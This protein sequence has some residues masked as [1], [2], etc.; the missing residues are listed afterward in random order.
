MTAPLLKVMP[1]VNQ[2]WQAA[3]GVE[4]NGK[5]FSVIDRFLR[6]GR[7]RE[8]DNAICSWQ[9]RLWTVCQCT[10]DI[11]LVQDLGK[12]AYS[13][14]GAGIRHSTGSISSQLARN[15][16][17]RKHEIKFDLGR[18]RCST[19][20]I[21]EPAS[22]M[23]FLGG[24]HEAPQEFDAMPR[25]PLVSWNTMLT[26][27][28]RSGYLS[29]A[30]VLFDLMPNR[31][32]VSWNAMISATLSHGNFQEA[33]DL[34]DTMPY[35]NAVSCNIMIVAYTNEGRLDL[36]EKLFDAMP[37][38][39]LLCCNSMLRGFLH[40][41]M[42]DRAISLFETMPLRDLVTWTTMIH[43]C[44]QEEEIHALLHGL[45]EHDITSANAA[46][47]AFA[48][49]GHM[50]SAKALLESME[51]RDLVSLNTMLTNEH[52]V[53]A[54][55]LAFDRMPERDVITFNAMIKLHAQCG[56]T[57]SS[58]SLFD[59]CPSTNLSSWNLLLQA[60][61]QNG[62]IDAG[63]GVFES[64]PERSP[65]SHTLMVQA[66]ALERHIPGVEYAWTSSPSSD[67]VLTT[68]VCLA[69]A[70]AGHLERSMA[71][72]QS[73]PQQPTAVAWTAMLTSLAYSGDRARA[74][75]LLHAV[76]I[77][78]I[79]L[80]AVVFKSVLIA[81]VHIGVL[82]LAIEQ[83][84]SMSFDFG[85]GPGKEH[86]RCVLNILARVGQLELAEDLIANMPFE[87][88]TVDWEALLAACVVHNDRQRGKRLAA[89]FQR[90]T[91]VAHVLL[92]NLCSTRSLQST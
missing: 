68:A 29:K 91:T 82:R 6:P 45:P 38:R 86:Y 17:P 54:A 70:Q 75:W 47:A 88:D 90:R 58:K 72:F 74:L 16:P 28:A 36:A 34:F 71:V 87:D 18:I 80:D 56:D 14:G 37:K 66:Y 1:E 15:D 9:P 89:K 25:K 5:S 53:E 46:L 43:G 55:K 7:I 92:A 8:A 84:V 23:D 57:E 44:S 35:Q 51:S 52:H 69:Y 4:G 67:V 27:Y 20:S 49:N 21:Q 32:T 61:V 3:S 48:Q 10:I 77:Q 40:C 59:R 50:D 19:R 81:C 78:G 64:M 76:K 39:S 83:F 62:H 13:G 41:D 24:I 31:N 85:L 60:Y 26:V 11:A 33:K 73:M 79:C 65:A 12:R 42:H 63:K 22:A 30:R 2:V